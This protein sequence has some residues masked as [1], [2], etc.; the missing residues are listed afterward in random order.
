MR[1]PSSLVLTSNAGSIAETGAL[2]TN[3][4]TGSAAGDASLTGTALSNRVGQL[5]SFSSGGTFSLNDGSGLTILGPLTAPTINIDTGPN[6]MTLADQA[7]IT[8]GGIERPP[9][10]VTTFPPNALTTNGAYL[11]TA[12]GFT[13]QGTSTIL[14]IGGGP[15]VLRID[16]TGNANITFDPVAGLQGKSTWLIVDVANGTISGQVT[17]KNLDV[18]LSGQTGSANLTGTV[19][20][21]TGPTTAGASHIQ[22]SPNSNFRINGCPIQSVTCVLLP[23]ESV[24][25]ANPLNDIDIGTLSNPNED[26]DLLLPIVSDQDY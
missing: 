14:G 13:Q 4:L 15:N 16:A 2:T 9:G 23:S 24:P 1:A 18:I 3:L 10:T 7:V 8:T 11:T 6:A 19:T 21:L 25:V 22:P 5:G 20:G 12:G 26:Q 17:V